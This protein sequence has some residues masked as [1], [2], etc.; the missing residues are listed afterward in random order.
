M[1][2]I[3]NFLGRFSQ[4]IGIDLGTANTLVYVHGQGV[5]INE[6][7]V[8]ALNTKT[9][10]V[11]AIGREAQRMV[12]KTPSHIVAIRPLRDGVISDFEVTEQMLSYFIQKVHEN[13]FHFMPRPRI[14]IG[15]PSSVTEVERRA[16][17]EAAIQAGAS[18]AYLMED[19]TAVLL[20]VNRRYTAHTGLRIEGLN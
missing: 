13:N 12:G 15:I 11:L 3:N 7:S 17:E 1:G 10:E 2:V 8:V 5:V 19:M 4:D 14:V 6:P 20:W 16:V 9:H 18:A